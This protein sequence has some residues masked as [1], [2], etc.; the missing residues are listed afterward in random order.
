MGNKIS[1]E[2]AGG[3]KILN[4]QP[5]DDRDRVDSLAAITHL[6][7]L[8][9]GFGPI[10][11]LDDGKHYIVSGGDATAGWAFEEFGAAG[12][13]STG[14]EK[15]DDDDG[16]GWKLIGE[17]NLGGVTIGLN[18]IDLTA[19]STTPAAGG[20]PTGEGAFVCGVDT[21]AFGP[22]SFVG[23]NNSY[24]H[25]VA[26]DSFLWGT[27]STT[28]G[29]NAIVLGHDTHASLADT[30]CIG[31]GLHITN[32]SLTGN[33]AIGTANEIITAYV[34]PVKV[35]VGIGSVDEDGAAD[36]RKNGLIITEDG[37]V[38][39]PEASIADIDAE[40]ERVL[41]TKEYLEAKFLPIT[42]A[43]ETELATYKP[44]MAVYDRFIITLDRE[45]TS[46]VEIQIKAKSPDGNFF[47]EKVDNVGVTE[48]V[49]V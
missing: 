49:R 43:D 7:T 18:S 14:L 6:V 41:I 29:P 38:I 37:A 24:S 11:N 25:T 10:L 35:V 15:R 34:S 8:Y 20:E 40:S 46:N 3:L 28:E 33:V 1:L 27:N 17:P 47:Y 26:S 31:L 9:L 22:R 2:I 23:G 16:A 21:V 45:D 5:S 30:V 13:F 44:T 4:P 48:V 32:S 12:D 39:A 19:G 42:V 36:V